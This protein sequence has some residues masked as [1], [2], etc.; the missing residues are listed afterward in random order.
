M[1]V[2]DIQGPVAP[3]KALAAQMFGKTVLYRCHIPSQK[4]RDEVMNIK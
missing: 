4:Y 1:S 2:A 3:L